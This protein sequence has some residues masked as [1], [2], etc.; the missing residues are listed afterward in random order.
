M[1]NTSEYSFTHPRLDGPLV[2]DSPWSLKV[3]AMSAMRILDTD[4]PA[5]RYGIDWLAAYL[6]GEFTVHRNGVEVTDYAAV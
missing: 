6:D 2:V 5:E 1:S 4:L 3:T